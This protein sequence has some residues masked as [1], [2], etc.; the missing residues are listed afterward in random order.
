MLEELLP[1]LMDYLQITMNADERDAEECVHQAFL[2]VYEQIRKDN[3]QNEKYIFMYL[4]RACRNEYISYARNQHKFHYPIDDHAHH[5]AEPAEQI[6]NLLEK[7][8]QM[9]L[10][11]CLKKM[12]P[13][14]RRFL[15]YFIDKPE[16]TTRQASK[17]FN[18]SG[19]NVRTKKSR[20]LTRLHHCVERKLG[21]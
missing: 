16:A 2:N 4:V 15:E 18:L 20:L 6:E 3:I 21:Q 13:K 7:E 10:E 1:R 19:G 14:S 9:I 5:L 11:D 12:K 8:R 17:H